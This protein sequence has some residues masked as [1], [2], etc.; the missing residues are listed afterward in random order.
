MYIVHYILHYLRVVM[1]LHCV[2]QIADIETQQEARD[3]MRT[4]AESEQKKVKSEIAQ[5]ESEMKNL[6]PNA[7]RLKGEVESLSAQLLKL[8]DRKRELK[9]KSVRTHQ[10][11]SR[12]E[13]DTW[14][15]S[16]IN[17]LSSGITQKT[18]QVR[19]S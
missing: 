5:L 9:L 16:Q 3:R 17:S 6:E 1:I 10:F 4:T 12:E 19:I 18:R 13:R 15:H 11:R 2:S 7:T 14:I 8:E